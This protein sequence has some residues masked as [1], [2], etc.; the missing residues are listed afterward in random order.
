MN[1]Y[2]LLIYQLNH[3]L[4]SNFAHIILIH[5]YFRFI[6]HIIFLILTQVLYFLNLDTIILSIIYPNF[7]LIILI[8]FYFR[9][10]FL[11]NYFY[12]DYIFLINFLILTQAHYFFNLNTIIHSI[13]YLIIKYITNFIDFNLIILISIFM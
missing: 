6:F 7:T 1:F 3:R 10:V 13:I 11:I 2:I 4:N 12:F 9:Y 5:F 8:Y